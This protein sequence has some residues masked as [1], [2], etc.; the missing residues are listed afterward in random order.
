MN[1]MMSKGLLKILRILHLSNRIPDRIY[2]KLIYCAL[3]GKTL[4]L[5][6]PST[7][8]EKLQWLKLY[9]RVNLY[10]I[11]VDKYE[12]KEYIKPLI[13]EE[14][15][16]PTLGVWDKFDDIDFN[17]LPQRFV[18]KCTHDSGGLVI[19][20]DKSKLN[21]ATA[22]QTLSASLKKDY[23][24]WGREWPYKNIKPRIIAEK[25]MSNSQLG[26]EEDE[27]T[28]YKIYCFNGKAK[29]MMIATGR[30]SKEQTHFDYFDRSGT[31]LDLNWG[32]PRSKSEPTKPE[33]FEE[34]FQ[35]AEKISKG[36]PH[37][38]VDLYVI[39]DVIYFGEMTFFDDGGFGKLSPEEWEY[40]LGNWL[41]LPCS[42]IL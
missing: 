37:V 8:N 2:V 5:K 18:L 6:N 19:C 10:T 20:T 34:L 9:N 24:S 13:G 39:A 17:K 31:W 29:L 22:K 1:Q 32:K 21:I 36:I 14:H 12:V 23:Y 41:E 27:L 40:K 42:P 38:R 3:T 15:I 30:F 4:N 33:K 11:L 25:Y 16:I 28:D 35:F 7:F 26:V